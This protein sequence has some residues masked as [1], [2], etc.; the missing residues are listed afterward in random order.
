[1]AREDLLKAVG[2][3][4]KFSFTISALMSGLKPSTHFCSPKKG[5][6]S[7]QRHSEAFKMF[8]WDHKFVDEYLYEGWSS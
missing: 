8:G 7:W 1:M 4:A 6:F 5:S 3:A 2:T